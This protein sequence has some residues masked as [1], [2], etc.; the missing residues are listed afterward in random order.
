[1]KSDLKFVEAAAHGAV[2]LA[3]PT[4]YA[5]TIRDGETGVICQSPEAFAD[6]LEALA[7]DPERRLRIA[8]AAWQWVRDNRM[9]ADQIAPRLA[10][11]RDLLARRQELSEALYARVPQLRG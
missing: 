11:Y 2:A 4:V 6:A 5:E 3:S 10:W 9:L 1:M 8:R 7:R